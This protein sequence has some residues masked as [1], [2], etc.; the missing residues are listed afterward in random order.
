M[1][2][3]CPSRLREWNALTDGLID[4]AGWVLWG[5][6]AKT[7]LLE[8]NTCEEKGEEAGLGRGSH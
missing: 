8:N 3:E 1:E 4:V 2:T 6:D 5:A 7:D